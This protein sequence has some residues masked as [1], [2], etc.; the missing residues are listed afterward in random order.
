MDTTSI[1]KDGWRP[2][3]WP[4]HDFSPSWKSWTEETTTGQKVLPRTEAQLATISYFQYR[5]P[6]TA[7]KSHISP[8]PSRRTTILKSAVRD[9]R[10][11]LILKSWRKEEPG[12]WQGKISLQELQRLNKASLGCGPKG[13]C[14]NHERRTVCSL[15]FRK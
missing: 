5:P 15:T 7:P 12:W 11:F 9:M 13:L 2:C 10:I 14:F 6:H 4:C 3:K 8:P 1:D